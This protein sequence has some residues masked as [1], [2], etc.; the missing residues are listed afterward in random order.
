MPVIK[1]GPAITTVQP[2]TTAYTITKPAA[3]DAVKKDDA[4]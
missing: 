2:V 1:T 4:L 3:M